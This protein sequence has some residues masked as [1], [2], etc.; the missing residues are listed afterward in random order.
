MADKSLD[1]HV[2]KEIRITPV[3]TY[4]GSPGAGRIVGRNA[5]ME[6]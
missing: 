5:K 4:F 2:I 1:G 6:N 3:E